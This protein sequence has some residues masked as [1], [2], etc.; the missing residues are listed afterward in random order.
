MSRSI[1][2]PFEM[3]MMM[4][5]ASLLI[6]VP[7]SPWLMPETFA[8]DTKERVDNENETHTDGH[9][10]DD[11]EGHDDDEAHDDHEGHDDDETHDDHEGH[12]EH[13]E[14]VIRLDEHQLAAIN[15]NETEVQRGSLSQTLTLPGEVHWNSDRV[16]HMTPRAGSIVLEVFKT[17]G[18]RV[19]VGDQ[20]TLLD[21]A[22]I[23][24][25]RMAYLETISRHDVTRAELKR[26]EQI[27]RN[28]RQ[29]LKILD[30]DPTSDVALEQAHDLQIGENKAK[31][32]G[33]YTRLQVARRTWE[34]EQQLREKK[35]SSEAD[36]LEAM[37]NFETSRSDYQSLREAIDYELDLDLLRH[38]N[39][40]QLTRMRML[41]A[42]GTLHMLGLTTS[43]TEELA[44]RVEEVDEHISQVGL[45]A[46]IE[47]LVVE[48]HLSPG[49][50]V[51]RETTLYKIV[52]T[53]TVWFMGRANERDLKLLNPGLKALVRLDAYPDQT[54]EGV[55]DYLG[56]ELDPESRTIVA[57]VVLP[58]SENR[59]RSGLF[60][61]V[62]V[63]TAGEG[64]GLLVP[65][66]ALQRTAEGHVVFKV[67]E[68]GVF[69]VVSVQVLKQSET[70]AQ[71]YG[72]LS[73][74]DRIATG[75]TLIL[76]TEAQREA[77][78]G[79][80]SH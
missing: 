49:E 16:V 33:I 65:T 1:A 35:I 80:H 55:V 42:K 77:L 69:E 52:D 38:R 70:F 46:P 26:L 45:A 59:L 76:K 23:G 9:E 56:S 22:E 44:R 29:L 39:A 25:A 79:G 53:K 57:R 31:L 10:D 61:Q 64:E 48:R 41:N 12:D 43:Q 14:G 68:P 17:L 20:L 34:R 47:G 24:Q 78:G 15:I 8:Q 75:D 27:A 13:E 7:F 37:S 32:L 72:D 4:L 50:Q 58:N 2:V 6:Y 28:T 40:L 5:V 71:I 30:G 21:S 62:T 51:N 74:G 11:H 3:T 19:V 36:Y 66:N 54:L 67:R 73:P 18:D 63:F 60:G